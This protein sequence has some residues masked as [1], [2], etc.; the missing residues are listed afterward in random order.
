MTGPLDKQENEQSKQPTFECNVRNRSF[1]S[2]VAGV[3]SAFAK[4]LSQFRELL[5]T[6]DEEEEKNDMCPR[7][8]ND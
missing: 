6:S 1:A 2:S 8:H 5:N 4:P 3:C 7:W